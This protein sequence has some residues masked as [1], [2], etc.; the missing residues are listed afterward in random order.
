MTPRPQIRPPG[1]LSASV[2]S[3]TGP[4]A[5][6]HL[7][8]DLQTLREIVAGLDRLEERLNV[9]PIPKAVT[10]R[11]Y[12]SPDEDDRVRQGV[13]VYR[14]CRLV[15][16]ELILRYR[17][18][19]SVEPPSSR[20][21]C[22]LVAFGAALMLYAKSLKIIAFAEH[23]PMLRAK[24]NEPDRK[25]DLE[26]G[27][28][29]DV[30]AG[31]S[32]LGNYR[33]VIQAD[34]F[35]RAHRR[36]AH[37]FAAEAGGDWVWL[38]DLIRRQ[39]HAVRNRLLH[40][41]WERLCHDWRAFCQALLSP[42]RQARQ[43]LESLLRDRLADVPTTGPPADRI[44]PVLLAELRTR[45]QPGDVLLVRD[46]QRLASAILPGFWTHAALYLG[47]RSD[48]ESLGLNTHPQVVRHGHEFPEN[49][50]PLGLVIE[51]LCP[52]VQLN[53][54]EKCLRVDHV[55]VL[56]PTLPAS[57]IAAAIGEAVGQLR[58]PYDFEF[59]FNNT[60]RIVCT[61]LVYRSL[62]HR[63]DI[64]F[65]LTKRLGRFTL[66]GDDIMAHAL[67]AIGAPGAV[68][69]PPLQPVALLLKRRDGQPHAVPAERILPLLRRI[70]RGW[71]P[72]RQVRLPKAGN[73]AA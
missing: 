70:R 13:L 67:D 42:F 52:C 15:A 45:L 28:F 44:P 59:D 72:S 16:Y 68:S 24:I 14:N 66:T 73:H 11:G 17:D 40:V 7:P 34:A 50:G 54:L 46:D 58:K 62:Q 12:F 51:A 27:F 41:L 35:W 8:A 61:E 6:R 49:P 2:P 21:R 5:E 9:S 36:E 53:P 30:L 56:R 31:Y 4:E 48:L 64:Q 37:A 3:L 1:G 32:R 63:G 57:E 23:V 33:S 10:E 25:Y 55:V 60:S 69:L 18:Y 19:A 47:G 39:R 22:F 29:D 20:L 38:V 71:H 43:G 65:A 26:E